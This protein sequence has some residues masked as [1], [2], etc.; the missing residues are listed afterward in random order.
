MVQ[1]NSVCQTIIYVEA[2]SIKISGRETTR[3]TPT[4]YNI[5]KHPWIS[6]NCIGLY[7]RVQY[8]IRSKAI[9][10]IVYININL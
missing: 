10:F 4:I 5:Y 6:G 3:W 1:L 8:Y 9:Y 2:N 7:Q